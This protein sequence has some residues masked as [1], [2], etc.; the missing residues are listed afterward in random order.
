MIAVPPQRKAI[1]HSTAAGKGI[2]GE[3]FRKLWPD[4]IHC[5]NWFPAESE[6]HH[7]EAALSRILEKIYQT[8][9][10]I[11]AE[12]AAE[13]TS[14]LPDEVPCPNNAPCQKF[15]RTWGTAWESVKAQ[16]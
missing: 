4:N 16:K 15:L 9:D 12:A 7:T 8:G 6:V 13:L 2:G 1:T 14:Q 5:V 11:N 3:R 10:P